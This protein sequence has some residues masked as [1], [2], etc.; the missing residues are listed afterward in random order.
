M[1]YKKQLCLGV[2]IILVMLMMNFV[3]AEEVAEQYPSTWEIFF[4]NLKNNFNIGQFSVVGDD[5]ACGLP[6][7]EPNKEWTNL[8]SGERFITVLSD[9]SVVGVCGYGKNGI[10]DVYTNGWVPFK[11]YKDFVD[12]ICQSS[13]CNIQL[14][15]CPALT[16]SSPTRIDCVQWS[17]KPSGFYKCPNENNIPYDKSFYRYCPVV[18]TMTCYYIDGSTCNSRTYDKSLFPNSCESYTY[19]G[20]KLYSDKS[21]CEADISV[22]TDTSW[23][24]SPSTVCS[25]ES[26]TQTSNCGNTRTSTGTKDCVVVGDADFQVDIISATPTI[27]SS[28]QD[29]NI[30]VKIK[31]NGGK[32]SMKVEVGL[33]K[34]EDITSWGFVAIQDAINCEPNEKNVDTKLIELNAGEE[35]TET[36]TI[37]TPKVC[38]KLIEPIGTF[39][40]LAVS[41]VNCMNTGL[42]TGVTSS[43]RFNIAFT[44]RIDCT[45]SC[46]NG[47]RDGEETDTDCGGSECDKCRNGWKCERI[48]DCQSGLQCLEGYCSPSDVS[49]GNQKGISASKI[50]QMTAEDL[51]ASACTKT[52]QCEEGSECQ[53]LEFL[54]D[55]G[56]LTDEEAESIIDRSAIFFT[57]AGAIG[58]IAA[59]GAA[60]L[61]LAPAAPILFPLCAL[62]GGALGLGIN[63]IFESFGDKDLSKSGYCIKEGKGLEI[64][65]WAA[66][67]DITG[68]G[69]KDGTDGLIIIVI[70]AAIL[71]LFIKR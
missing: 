60:S 45:G 43:D 33:Y 30:N 10:Y 62:A 6:G 11:E 5:M 28:E 29:V 27:F 9:K 64:F 42:A 19:Q 21:V 54:V 56:S 17:G 55:K 34:D 69:V 47:I 15:C 67:F 39:D 65:K 4:S 36:F 32:G 7:G 13:P 16:C 3:V 53:S 18:T 23:T 8:Q 71:I 2:V 50:K 57:S 63:D 49:R 66:W 48:T 31:N 46:T 70:G 22:C 41:F 58:G 35:I 51:A 37:I 61:V 44:P 25:G 38:R 12:I 1:K 52:I 59:C 14:Y 68:D 40:L 26:F 20:G 24:P